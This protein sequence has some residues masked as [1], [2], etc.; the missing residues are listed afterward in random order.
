MAAR[1]AEAV[2]A[3]RHRVARLVHQHGMAAPRSR[4]GLPPT[5]DSR[6]A[7]PS[8]AN[9]VQRRFAAPAPDRIWPADLACI[10]AR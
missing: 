3:G 1:R 7:V 6:H 4:P 10:V 5:T 9:L 2:R 8:A